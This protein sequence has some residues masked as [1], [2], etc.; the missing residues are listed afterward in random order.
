MAASSDRVE[1]TANDS[2]ILVF[3]ILTNEGRIRFFPNNELRALSK[4]CRVLNAEVRPELTKR[5]AAE[6]M[7]YVVYG[8]QVKAKY[9][10]EANPRLLLAKTQYID[11][12]GRTI[13]GTPFQA[14]LGAE[15]SPMW[16][17]MIPYFT[18][19]ERKNKEFSAQEEMKKQFFEQFPDGIESYPSSEL[20]SD[21]ND[22]VAAIANNDDNGDAA[23]EDF[24]NQI[25][26]H[27]QV[28]S[29]KHFNMQ[30][31]ITAYQ[32]YID[33]FDALETWSNR[34]KYWQKVI[35]Y[36]QTQMPANYAQAHCSVRSA[37]VD[38]SKF[39]RTFELGGGHKFFPLRKMGRLGFDYGVN[40]RQGRDWSRCFLTSAAPTIIQTY[41][42]LLILL[43]YV[44]QKTV[45]LV[46]FM[47]E[48][49]PEPQ[50]STGFE[51]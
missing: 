32:A 11:Y 4:T 20:Q 45:S 1:V 34:D 7:K 12:S 29:G 9:M 15:D 47:Q 38:S 26:E 23:I 37:R 36:V 39:N 35:G 19:L 49:N 5:A 21:Y 24:R 2:A 30:H 13:F 6:V 3:H 48:L 18:K 51:R 42:L 14:A 40:V 22:L 25:S 41:T 33:N 46:S 31:L 16:E 8:E 27:K 50:K 43:N 44:K 17:M 28:K 10:I